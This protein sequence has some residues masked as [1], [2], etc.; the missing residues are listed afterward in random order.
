MIADGE[1]HTVAEGLERCDDEGDTVADV[2][3]VA[4]TDVE[5]VVV[6][7]DGVIEAE[8][9]DVMDEL[10]DFEPLGVPT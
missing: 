9:E 8:V 7:I 2:D 1:E 10:E 4:P 5:G 3:L 6:T